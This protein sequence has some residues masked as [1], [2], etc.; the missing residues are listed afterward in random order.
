[1]RKKAWFRDV[2]TH[3]QVFWIV[4]LSFGQG[5]TLLIH[6]YLDWGFT[7]FETYFDVVCAL[8]SSK[9][10]LRP[11]FSHIQLSIIKRALKNVAYHCCCCQL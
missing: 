9:G 1:M 11:L 2:F 8:A 3:G 10:T 7:H 4:E 5:G 6:I